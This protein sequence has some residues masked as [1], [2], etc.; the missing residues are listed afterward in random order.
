MSWKSVKLNSQGVAIK[1]GLVSCP[2]KTVPYILANRLKLLP[3]SSLNNTII[4]TTLSNVVSAFH[5][6]FSLLCTH[7]AIQVLSLGWML[8]SWIKI[9]KCGVGGGGAAIR[10]SQC[11]FFENKFSQGVPVPD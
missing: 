4:D 5:G 10:M 2:R 7:L 6:N 8:P 9:N 3:P 1:G 11:T